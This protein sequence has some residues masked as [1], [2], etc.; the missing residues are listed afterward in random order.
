[1]AKELDIGHIR[2]YD[3]Y[4]PSLAA[5]NYK[6]TVKQSIGDGIGLTDQ[7]HTQLTAEQQFIV[8]APQFG[9]D[10]SEVHSMVPPG[11]STG[12]FADEFPHLVLNTRVLPWEREMRSETTPWLALLV[13]REGELLAGP[14][15]RTDP[16]T[17]AIRSTVGQFMQ[18]K[19]SP[20]VYVPQNLTREADVS[21]NQ[22]CFYIQLEA[23]L[24][25]TVLPYLNELPYLTHVRQLNT[26]DKLIAGLKDDG[27]FSVV[28][29]N[30]LPYAAEGETNGTR[31][32][33][34]L[35]SLEKL[36]DL[37]APD[38]KLPK[39]SIALLSLARWTFRCLPDNKEDFAG[40][41]HNLVAAEIDGRT[42]A[43][44]SLWLRLPQTA[45]DDGVEDGDSA[46]DAAHAEV[47]KRLKNGYVPL[48]FHTRSGED[49]FAWYRGPLTPVRPD[50]L[51]A[52]EPFLSA[53]AALIYDK[54]NGLFDASL[55]SAWQIGRSLALSDATFGSM[56]LDYRRRC[57]RLTDTL[58]ENLTALGLTDTADLAELA[59]SGLMQKAL[60]DALEQDLLGQI[61]KPPLASPA[62]EPRMRRVA[63]T[64]PNPAAVLQ[65]FLNR[66][67]VKQTIA[68]LTREAL[69]PIAEWLAHKQLLYEVPFYHIVPDSR[70]LP[71]ESIRFFYVDPNWLDAMLDGMLAVAMHSSRDSFYYRL[72]K[73]TIGAAVREAMYFLRTKQSGIKADPPPLG[74]PP[75]SGFL[76]RSAVVAGWPGMAVRAFDAH[77]GLL[78]IARLERLSSNVL[79]GLFWGIPERLEFSEPQES[80]QFGLNQDGEINL[81]TVGTNDL[82]MPFGSEL[83]VHLQVRDR[84]LRSGMVLDL[85]PDRADG[86][87]QQAA[88]A[89]KQ[90]LKQ[91]RLSLKPSDFALQMVK[92]PER[93]EFRPWSANAIE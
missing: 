39:S 60:L 41:M 52:A 5:G 35:V 84:F 18:M 2:F 23:D 11:G 63:A 74:A 37:L 49:T 29:A 21:D 64:A 86:L 46:D 38:S 77:D 66:D 20:D 17:M 3:N 87:V 59:Q 10:P 70:M 75:M 19:N 44:D 12:K 15:D 45:P 16:E 93:I 40:L 22:A 68:G 36:D 92:S 80:F 51:D 91:E 7:E 48:P 50:P 53:D 79:I 9:I 61:P 58:F 30:R 8:H 43:P 76:L 1:M 42:Y 55:A 31:N 32:I 57:H 27:W 34:H 67:D 85:R 56:L 54:S 47:R 71:R 28:T 4:L 88:D 78:K 25:K 62:D 33:V 6:I 24:F 81:R 14:T 89:I 72:T 82:K 90:A 69:E 65:Q 83:N 26:G 73:G 13:F